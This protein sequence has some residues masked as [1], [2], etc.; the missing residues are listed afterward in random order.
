MK[1]LVTLCFFIIHSPK[2][3]ENSWFWVIAKK[4]SEVGIFKPHHVMKKINYEAD[5][6]SS[7]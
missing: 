7:D 3:L 4:Y 2:I 1:V 5:F 6:C